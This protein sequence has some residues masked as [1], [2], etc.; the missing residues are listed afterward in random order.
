M[1]T[2]EILETGLSVAY[3]LIFGLLRSLPESNDPHTGKILLNELCIRALSPRGEGETNFGGSLV[4][5]QSAF[6]GFPFCGGYGEGRRAWRMYS[7]RHI[8]I[9]EA[10]PQW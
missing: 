3:E 2:S 4:M 10:S 5:G 6:G 8:N 7:I 1:E 9:C